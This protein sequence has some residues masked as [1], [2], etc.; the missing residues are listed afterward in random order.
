MSW[1][2]L[3]GRA[4]AIGAFA[5]LA[6]TASVSFAMP[7]ASS[8]SAQERWLVIGRATDA[9]DRVAVAAAAKRRTTTL[10]VRVRVTGQPKTAVLHTVVTCSKAGPVGIVVL[11]RRGEFTVTAPATRVQRL[12]GCAS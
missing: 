5:V 2:R 3:C 7:S 6:A 11:S 10:A 8:V 9:G 4:V 12:V 1:R